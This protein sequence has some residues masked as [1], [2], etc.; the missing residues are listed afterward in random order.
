MI[1]REIEIT[2]FREKLRKLSFTNARFDKSLFTETTYI[3]D[4][5]EN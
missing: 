2:N 3:Y 4:Q 5:L 1:S